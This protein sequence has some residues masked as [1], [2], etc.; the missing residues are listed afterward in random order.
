MP[1]IELG[2][3]LPKRCNP[4]KHSSQGQ[5]VKR[6]FFRAAVTLHPLVPRRGIEPLF[7]V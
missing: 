1:R 6:V 7:V 3:D 5:G 4:L 2:P